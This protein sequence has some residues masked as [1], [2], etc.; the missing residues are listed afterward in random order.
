M[1]RIFVKRSWQTELFLA[2]RATTRILARDSDKSKIQVE[3]VLD[4]SIRR[5]VD[6]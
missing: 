1:T 4:Q 5:E 3:I 2:E 6:S